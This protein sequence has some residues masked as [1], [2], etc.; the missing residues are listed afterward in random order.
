MSSSITD[1]QITES[2]TSLPEPHFDEEATVLSAR[3]VV[4]LEEVEVLNSKRS[5]PRPWILGLGLVG[6]LLVGICATV[7]YYSRANR[8]DSTLL[9]GTKVSAGVELKS[10]QSANSFSGPAASQPKVVRD[11]PAEVKKQAA[12]NNQ[13]DRTS[14]EPD[15]KTRPRLVAV[16][17]ENQRNNHGEEEDRAEDLE[18]ELKAARKRAKKERRRAEREQRERRS[19]DELLRIRDIFEGSPRP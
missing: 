11:A 4:P 5:L 19:S 10:N 1:Q 2:G 9:H 8:D 6:A 18:K 13:P 3:P 12:L 14:A 15:K 7:I 17:R 16:I